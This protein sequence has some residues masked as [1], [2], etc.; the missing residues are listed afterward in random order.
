MMY[1]I[2]GHHSAT[3][4]RSVNA[5][6]SAYRLGNTPC[7]GVER[8][9]KDCSRYQNIKNNQNCDNRVGVYCNNNGLLYNLLTRSSEIILL[10]L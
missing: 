5:R 8:R 1:F 7:I 10:L 9:L 6:K 2:C 4:T 3:V